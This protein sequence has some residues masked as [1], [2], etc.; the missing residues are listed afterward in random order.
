VGSVPIHNAEGLS[1][2]GRPLDLGLRIPADS[3]STESDVNG[4]HTHPN[5]EL[6][7]DIVEGPEEFQSYGSDG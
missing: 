5:E 2:S 6:L 4:R 1:K 3:P 7:G